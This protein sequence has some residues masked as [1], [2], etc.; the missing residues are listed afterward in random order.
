M[1]DEDEEKPFEASQKR[2]DDMRKEGRIPR[3]QDLLTAAAYAGFVLAMVTLGPAMLRQMGEALMQPLARAETL[4]PALTAAARP[5]FGRVVLAPLWPLLPLFVLPMAAVLL[6]LVVQKA[7]IFTPANLMPRLSRI[8]PLSNARNKF[9]PNGLFEFLKS[10]MKLGVVAT[11]LALFLGSRLD[12]MLTSSALSVPAGQVVLLLLLRDF[13]AV[14]LVV[15]LGF[16]L[17]DYIWQILRHRREARMSRQEMTDEHKEAEGDPHSRAQRRQ[18]GQEIAL[19]RML[20]DVAGADVVI[21][22]PTH[23]AVALKWDRA[24]GRAPVCVA[25]GVDEIAA[26]IRNQAQQAGVPIHSDPPTARALHASVR[27]G[28]E[29]PR[30]HYRA[31]AAAIRF[32]EA[33]RRKARRHAP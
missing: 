28:S 31:V 23:Y 32:A 4:A 6:V 22:N 24:S 7:V 26:R 1:S 18:R 21:V 27:I 5:G 8:S 20:R 19:N 12:L 33:M 2:L 30:D 17:V 9:G 16:G 3:S 29:I 14:V 11:I 15:A 10:G 25:K 13:F